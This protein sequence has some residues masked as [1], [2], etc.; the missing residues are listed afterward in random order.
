MTFHGEMM[1][2]VLCG[3]KKRSNPKK[4]TQ[5]RAIQWGEKVFYCCPKH[6]PPDDASAGE[7]SAAYR[8]FIMKVAELCPDI[9]GSA[10]PNGNIPI[11]PKE[12]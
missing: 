6:F 11:D 12:S 1:T 10:W 4:N 8:P 2:C 7:F 3:R 9:R 5:W